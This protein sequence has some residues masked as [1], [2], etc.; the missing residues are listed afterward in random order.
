MR[1]TATY[2]NKLFIKQRYINMQCRQID[3]E[4]EREKE[5]KKEK[6]RESEM[7]KRERLKKRVDKMQCIKN[8]TLLKQITKV[9][10]V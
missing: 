3:E 10:H 7:E 6:A 5:R 9:P 2:R 1:G 4:R 8:E